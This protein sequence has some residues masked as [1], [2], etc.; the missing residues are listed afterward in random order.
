MMG[1]LWL[2][3]HSRVHVSDSQTARAETVALARIGLPNGLRLGQ[4]YDQVKLGEDGETI[5]RHYCNGS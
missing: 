3:T 5:S 4:E 2:F 1:L